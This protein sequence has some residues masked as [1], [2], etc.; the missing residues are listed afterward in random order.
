MEDL[1]AISHD[2]DWPLEVRKKPI[3]SE[4]VVHQE[5]SSLEIDRVIRESLHNGMS[6][7]HL[8]AERLAELK[9]DLILTQELCEVCAP[10][11]SDVERAAKILDAPPKIISLEPQRVYDIL[12]NIALIG[13]LTDRKVEADQLIASL[14]R[15]IDRIMDLAEGADEWPRVLALEW[16]SPLF[17]AGHWVP[18][19]IEWAGG[20]PLGEPEEPSVEIT[21]DDVER[22]DPEILVLM[23]CGFSPE[24]TLQEIELLAD[25]ENWKELR[26]VKHERVYITHGT[27]YFNR[28]GPRIVTGLE[29]LAAITQPELFGELEI[30]E[31]A[32]Y[33][34]EDAW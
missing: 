27:H 4:A 26:A 20:I 8:D 28:P 22:F 3:L 24:R 16:L 19:M 14:T 29:I 9:P 25:Y 17:V 30:P 12:G 7:Y 1:V 31:G 34:W 11:F 32:L 15:R 6:V 5:L 18:E 23:P 21:W 10:S 13:E 2:C 33:L